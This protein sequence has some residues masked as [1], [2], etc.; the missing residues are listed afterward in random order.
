MQIIYLFLIIFSSVLS[1]NIIVFANEYSNRDIQLL[2]SIIKVEKILFEPQGDSQIELIGYNFKNLN[3]SELLFFIK[4]ELRIA[5][6]YYF[7]CWWKVMDREIFSGDFILKV[8]QINVARFKIEVKG[9]KV[10]EAFSTQHLVRIPRSISYG[11]F[12]LE[13]GFVGIHYDLVS[14]RYIPIPMFIKIGDIRILNANAIIEHKNEIFNR[15][16][17]NLLKNGSF[18]NNLSFWTSGTNIPTCN[19]CIDKNISF[20]GQNSLM[21]EF[22]GG[23][24]HSF[25]GPTQ[26]VLVKPNTKYKLSYMLKTK[27]I[28]IVKNGPMIQMMSGSDQWNSSEKYTGTNDWT[29]VERIFMTSDNTKEITLRFRRFGGDGINANSYSLNID[30]V[31]GGTAWFDCVALNEVKE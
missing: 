25:L 24:S 19:L 13:S 23:V 16:K 28:S 7:N 18:E 29:L 17:N 15:D 6:T 30:K 27:D 14:D 21:I 12:S 26:L 11:L 22:D 8:G 10:G 31:I 1:S 5:E 20:H 9:K 3:D 4:K 2:N